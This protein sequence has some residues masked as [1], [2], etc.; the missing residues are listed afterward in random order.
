[1]PKKF[2]PT[3]SVARMTVLSGIITDDPAA[4]LPIGAKLKFRPLTSA[5]SG[6][7]KAVALRDWEGFEGL[8]LSIHFRTRTSHS[9][10]G[11]SAL[12][13]PGIALCAD[14]VIGP[15]IEGILNGT[16]GTLVTGLTTHG[17]QIWNVRK[18][19]LVPGTD[20]C[21][22]GLS[23]ASEL[24]PSNV[25]C[26]AFMTTRLPRVGETLTLTG[27]RAGQ[28]NFEIIDDRCVRLS[29]N[30]LVCAGKVTERYPKRRD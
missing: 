16:I 4:D 25:F 19:T 10:D 30:V 29:G 12:V 15:Y 28:Q 21:I 27:F 6:S 13:G 2:L 18:I 20:F 1:M 7:E 26:Q 22:L 14:H 5:Y 17:V 3:K 24:P 8:L 9:I 11:S 23:A